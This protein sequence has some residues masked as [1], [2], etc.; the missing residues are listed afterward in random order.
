M[1]SVVLTGTPYEV[2]HQL[3]DWVHENGHNVE[4]LG[5]AQ[6]QSTLRGADKGIA[7]V[8]VV[9]SIVYRNA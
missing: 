9:L 3:T 4:I 7:G 6:S 2:E 8:H 1:N 5:M